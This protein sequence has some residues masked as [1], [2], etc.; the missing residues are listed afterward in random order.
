MCLQD[1]ADADNEDSD[2][3]GGGDIMTAWLRLYINQLWSLVYNLNEWLF[4]LKKPTFGHL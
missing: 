2:G 4:N 1:D 3:G